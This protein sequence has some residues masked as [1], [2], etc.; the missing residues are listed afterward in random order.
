MKSAPEILIVGSLF[1]FS[2]AIVGF[3]IAGK[4]VLGVAIF[5]SLMI[6]LAIGWCIWDRHDD[7]SSE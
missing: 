6:G 7:R 2:G 5:G 1:A 3:L 4:I